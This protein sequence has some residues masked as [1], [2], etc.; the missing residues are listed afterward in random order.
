M[1]DGTPEEY[2]LLADILTE[3]PAPLLPIPG[4]HDNPELFRSTFAHLDLLP[5]DGAFHYAV[6]AGDL[7][8]VALDTT[9]PGRNDGEITAE[10]A[11][12]LD[13]QLSAARDQPTIVFCHH[14]PYATGAWWSD[15]MGVRGADLLRTVCETHHQVIRVVSG[16]VHR[17]TQTQWDHLVLSSAPSTAFAVGVGA[18]DYETAAPT[19]SDLPSSAPLFWWRD[20]ELLALEAELDLPHTRIDLH[21]LIS[22]WDTYEANA[23][24]G[25]PMPH[26]H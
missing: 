16:H 23:R 1:N 7:M 10:D 14:V 4:N 24:S 18:G 12:Q 2:E 13:A 15:Y 9:I 21:D 17:A 25:A 19:V 5:D 26:E 3:A 8:L 6:D 20:D 22:D 11:A